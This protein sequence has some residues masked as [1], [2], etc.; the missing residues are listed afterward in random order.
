MKTHTTP[1]TVRPYEC[2]PY[3]H[4][5]HA[6]YLHYLEV[7]RLDYMRAVGFDYHGLLAAGYIM[8]IT[9]IDITY[10]AA[11]LSEDTLAIESTPIAVRRVTGSMKQTIRRGDT[12]IVE[13]TVEWCIVTR[14][15]HPARPPSAYDLR[16]AVE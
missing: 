15:G 9:R 11:A 7:A 12:V 14:D 5:N 4:V 13:A 2:D 8:P 6:R 1:L 16:S 10:R 3:G